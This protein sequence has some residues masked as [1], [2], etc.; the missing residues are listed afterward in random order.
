MFPMAPFVRATLPG[1]RFDALTRRPQ[2]DNDHAVQPSPS[3][4]ATFLRYGP[5]VRALMGADWI[6]DPHPIATVGSTTALANAFSVGG[7]NLYPVVLGNGSSVDVRLSGLT[8]QRTF[9]VLHPTATG[10]G[11]WH[12]LQPTHISDGETELTVPL[13]CGCGLLRAL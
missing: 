9:A 8:G 2:P 7:S 5:L 12:P 3:K 4:T 6:L 1:L 13:E 11:T 10:A